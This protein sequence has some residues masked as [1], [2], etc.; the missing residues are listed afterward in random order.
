MMNFTAFYLTIQQVE[1]LCLFQLSWG[2]GQNLNVNVA[3]PENLTKLYQEWQKIYLSFYNTALRGKVANMGSLPT[4]PIDWHARLVQA[5]AQFLSVFHNWLRSAE[6]FDIRK[7]I[8]QVSKQNQTRYLDIFIACITPDLAKL[9]WEVWEIGTEFALDSSQIRIVRTATNRRGTV[10]NTQGKYPSKARILVILGDDT[11]LNF[12]SE[13]QAIASLKDYADVKFIGWQPNKNIDD[14]KTEIVQTISCQNGWNILFFAGH[15]NQTNL[16]GGELGIAPGVA[17]SISE[18]EPALI[19]A[20]DRGLQCAIFNSCN[21]LSIAD[22]LI[23]LG[24]S[25]VA[26]MREPIHNQVAEV[27]LPCFLQALSEYKDVHESLI[28]AA[29][30]L[31]VEK[32][33]TYPSAYLIPSLFRHP[34]A[35]LFRLQ[36]TFINQVI[37]NLVP[38]R[39]ELIVVSILLI[40]SLL[41]PV[42]QFLLQRRI[43]LQAIYRQLTG[44]VAATVATVETP[45]VLLIEI[46]EDSIRKAKISNPKPI[47]RKYLANLIDKLTANQ[48]KIIGIDYLLDRHQGESDRI[49]ANSITTAVKSAKPTWFVFA[50]TA[51]QD[52]QWLR[53]LPNIADL[54]WSLEGE[55]E[56]LPGYMQLLPDHNSQDNNSQSS[57]PDFS[58]LLNPGATSIWSFSGLLTLGY[59][60]QQFSDVPQPKLDSQ[61]DFFQQI[62]NFLDRQVQDRSHSQTITRFS[63]SLY[64]M[65]MHPIIDF[66]ISPQSVYQN[67][68]AWQLL[69]NQNIPKNLQNLQDIIV[70]IAPGGYEE[71]GLNYDGED[72]FLISK[73]PAIKYWRDQENPINQSQISQILTGGEY[74]AYMVHHLLTNRL[75]IPI[76]DFWIVGIA[77]FIGKGL[78]L[79]LVLY[80]VSRNKSPQLQSLILV[81]II[82]GIYGLISLQVYISATAILLP[83]LLPS[84]T[85][86][87]YIISAIVE[88]KSDD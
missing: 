83:C 63:Y 10:I 13:K 15:S 73:F 38:N 68:P 41:L 71:A 6:L 69:E 47:D 80:L 55:I 11:G 64:Q 2:Q 19:T 24:I 16:T 66:S 56:I 20:K 4:P 52:G 34:G 48:A 84:I 25:Q 62:N 79:Y 29:Q 37:E 40:I 30:Y 23:D 58:K 3:Y 74:H 86:W 67:I 26:V 76:P 77:I 28:S 87:F 42:Q 49:L 22:K 51:N 1:K 82:T 17:L 50:G 43:L 35:E 9:P 5:E 45:P 32:N 53:V 60:L 36:P 75:V 57:E 85:L 70:I 54:N 59:Q 81:T 72:N 78:N 31:K 46:D 7:Q 61:E 21:G 65:W 18:L 8:A 88:K 14:L 33:F 27:F 39:R 44:Q 12:E